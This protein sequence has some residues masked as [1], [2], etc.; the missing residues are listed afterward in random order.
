M[1][2][3]LTSWHVRSD[4]SEEEALRHWRTHHVQL[5]RA[6]PGLRRYVQNHCTQGPAADAGAKLPYTG[7]GEVWFE[8]FAAAQA[9]MQTPEWKVVLEDAAT[10]MDMARLTAVWAH[11]HVF[12]P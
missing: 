7:L 10:F 12:H 6:L 2:K 5:V 4:V 3:R 8:D 11:E 9:A 1:I